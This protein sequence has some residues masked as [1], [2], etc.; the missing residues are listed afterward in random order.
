[1][2]KYIIATS[3]VILCAVLSCCF[4][5]S[6]SK[7]NLV[8]KPEPVYTPSIAWTLETD[9]LEGDVPIELINGFLY[10]PEG[11][12]LTSSSAATSFVQLTKVNPGTG[13]YEWKTA[14]KNFSTKTSAV[15]SGQYIFIMVSR[16][17]N[18]KTCILCYDDT[19]GNLLA[20]IKLGGTDVLSQQ[21]GPFLYKMISY[22]NYLYWGNRGWDNSGNYIPYGL[23]RFDINSI[24]FSKSAEEEQVIEP[25]LIWETAVRRSVWATPV[26]K[27]GIIYFI[28]K[29]PTYP[30]E[31]TSDIVAI[32]ALTAEVKWKYNQNIMSGLPQNSLIIDGERLYVVDSSIG[33]Y[34]INNGEKY[35][36]IIAREQNY[37]KDYCL[38]NSSFSRGVFFYNNRLYYT[39]QASWAT[40]G[41]TEIPADMVKNILC[42]DASNGK[43][44]WG[45]IPKGGGSLGTRPIVVNGRTYVVSDMGLRVYNAD[46]GELIGVDKTVKNYGSQP[47]AYYNNLVIYFNDDFVKRK[48]ILTAIKAD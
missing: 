37:K 33:C 4:F 21:N 43:Y 31:G 44:V 41:M 45:D 11:N 28:T 19:S 22:Q 17:D 47:N 3:A 34:N 39:T 13:V 40:S 30:E 16:I 9:Y 1:M 23:M 29:N 5:C 35:F 12:F 14:K 7:E 2:K 24:D 25:Q 46:T 48:G 10:I 20:T 6:G 15:K 32:D 38:G 8:E 27:N 36:E 18:F 26:E 42:V